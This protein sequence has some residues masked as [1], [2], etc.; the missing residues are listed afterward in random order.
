MAERLLLLRHARIPAGHA[1]R[2]V[3]ATD[4]PLDAV[5]R[6]QARALAGRLR[7]WS[8]GA[9]YCSPMQRC[10]QTAEAAAPELPIRFDRDLREIDFGQWENRTFGELERES[11]G[12]IDRWAAF[13]EDFAFPGGETIGEFLGRVRAAAGR[14]MQD[15]A[16]TVLAVTHGGV[17]R[18]MIC[19]LLG[20]ESRKYVAFDVAYASTAVIDLHDGRGVLAAMERLDGEEVGRG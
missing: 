10:R 20:F 8:P 15:D 12:L 17:I 4:V 14:L 18:T 1:G 19:H 16:Q 2:L 9:C 3:G 11:P 7:R 13:G 5:G 6:S